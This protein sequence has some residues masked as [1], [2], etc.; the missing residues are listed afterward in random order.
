MDSARPPAPLVSDAD[1]AQAVI[2]LRDAAV[3]GRLTLDEFSERVEHTELARTTDDLA[4]VLAGLPAAHLGAADAPARHHAIFS[5]LERHGRWELAADSRALCVGATIDLDLGQAT[6]TAAQTTLKIRNW[7]GTVTI[8][9]PRGVHVTVDGG[10]AFS[11]RDI[12]LPDAGSV[13]DA[14]RL[15]IR[16]SGL[17][18]TVR[19]RSASSP[20]EQHDWLA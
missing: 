12:E 20:A 13:P 9:V 1:R 14:P 6:L 8:V 16:T 11:S 17:G 5:R 4:Q 19:I 10:G 2:A 3:D 18:G 15:H 7:F